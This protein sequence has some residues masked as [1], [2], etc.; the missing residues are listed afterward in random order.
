MQ[1][2]LIELSNKTFITK[3]SKNLTEDSETAASVSVSAGGARKDIE[4]RV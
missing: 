1:P 3:P 2:K 4:Y